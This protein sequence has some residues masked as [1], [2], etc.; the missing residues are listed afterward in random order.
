MKRQLDFADDLDLED[1]LVEQPSA[2]RR[3]ISTEKEENE[4]NRNHNRNQQAVRNE[5]STEDEEDDDDDDD[6]DDEEEEGE[7]LHGILQRFKA[8]MAGL[9]AKTRENHEDSLDLFLSSLEDENPT[10]DDIHTGTLSN[11]LGYFL[12]RKTFSS[13]STKKQCAVTM[14]KLCGWLEKEKL[15]KKGSTKDERDLCSKA[16][17]DLVAADRLERRL[18]EMMSGDR[19]G[20][21][22][23]LFGFGL[24]RLQQQETAERDTTDLIYWK[25]EEIVADKWRL[26]SCGTE[27]FEVGYVGFG[28]YGG[29]TSDQQNVELQV[30]DE[31]MA[32]LAKVGWVILMALEK[33]KGSTDWKNQPGQTGHVWPDWTLL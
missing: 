32:G 27:W 24:Q 10:L 1:L 12:I 3:R 23:G 25:I 29:D 4:L 17:K 20:L 22:G 11:F 6:D 14:K 16:A 13:A 9:S 33:E 7:S 5:H 8:S 18:N 26:K 2:K 19:S 31:Q 15:K 21:F 30:S 28:G